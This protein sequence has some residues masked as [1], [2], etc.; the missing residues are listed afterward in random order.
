MS[1]AELRKR[2]AARVPRW[3]SR[4]SRPSSITIE[5]Q[6]E[7]SV[8]RA[9][10]DQSER[11]PHASEVLGEQER[12]SGTS[13][14]KRD[15]NFVPTEV[16]HSQLSVVTHKGKGRGLY[17][18]QASQRAEPGEVLLATEPEVSVLSTGCAN[19][20]CHFC[21]RPST[22]LRRCSQCK[23]SRYCGEDCQKRAW[24]QTRHCDECLALQ[25]WQK[26]SSEA[27]HYIICPSATVRA[28]AQVVWQRH[29]KGAESRYAQAIASLETHRNDMSQD[30][31]TDCAQTA[32]QLAHFLTAEKLPR[33]GIEHATDLLSLVCAYRINAFTLA[34][35]ELDPIGVSVSVPMA[36]CNHACVPNAV[37]VFP[38]SGKRTMQLVAISPIEPGTEVL[39]S[40]VDL[41]ETLPQ[42]QSTLSQR[43]LFQCQCILCEHSSQPSKRWTDPRNA[44]WCEQFNC[45]GWVTMPNWDQA[46]KGQDEVMTGPCN[47]CGQCSRLRAAGAIQDRWNSAC[48]LLATM[49]AKLPDAKKKNSLSE[50]L[51]WIQWLSTLV[52]PSNSLLWSLMHL[53]HVIA[54]E[55]QK[56]AEATQLAFV[57]CAGMQARGGS[58]EPCTLYPTG[59]PV[60]AVLLATLGK[61][62]LHESEPCK[63]LLARISRLPSDRQ[64][65]LVLSKQ[66]LIQALT[67][68]QTGFGHAARGGQVADGVR[69]A[70]QTLQHEENILRSL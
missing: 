46:Q 55:E 66:A 59:H 12:C 52:P 28:L 26:G 62:L 32:V 61:L 36:L 51:D 40:Y 41:V 68:S 31:L 67:E 69:E 4:S 44:G 29:K 10:T 45:P 6:S 17:R 21:F 33:Y 27:G 56:F 18:S 16:E 50:L 63:P 13:T 25:A 7:A 22:R 30:Q 35:P 70:L 53:A 47:S 38:E 19:E 39:T 34:S 23:F 24:V 37:V 14:S 20:R 11:K 58:W 3:S 42:R 60:R 57:L 9:R 1:F 2:R 5:T 48:T 15:T 54:I 65:Q 43:Y 49:Q 8:D 64:T